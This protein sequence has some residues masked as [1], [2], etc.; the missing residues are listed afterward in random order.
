[1]I[2]DRGKRTTVGITITKKMTMTSMITERVG[3]TVTTVI[4]TEIRDHREGGTIMMTMKRTVTMRAKASRIAGCLTMVGAA[5]TETTS[6]RRTGETPGGRDMDMGVSGRL[7]MAQVT[8]RMTGRESGIGTETERGAPSTAQE[9]K[10]KRQ[11]YR[12]RVHRAVP[13]LLST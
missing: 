9:E 11:K 10:H 8:R 2:A 1:M 13:G 6:T 7:P 3:A 12:D 5:V 4:I